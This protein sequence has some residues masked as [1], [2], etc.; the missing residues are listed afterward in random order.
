MANP[1]LITEGPVRRA[2]AL[3]LLL[4]SRRP[5]GHPV[6]AHIMS[7]SESARRRAPRAS[8]EPP[9]DH[10][11]PA[12]ESRPAPE[13][14]PDLE[15]F[16]CWADRLKA[17]A[18][19][20]GPRAAP[21]T[22]DNHGASSGPAGAD[23]AQ[24]SGPVIVTD[25]ER[26]VLLKRLDRYPAGPLM[27][28]WAAQWNGDGT[29]APE[30]RELRL[31]GRLLV[32]RAILLG[33]DG[34]TPAEISRV[35]CG[36][37]L[38]RPIRPDLSKP[39]VHADYI[40]RILMSWNSSRGFGLGV[41][42][43]LRYAAYGDVFPS[44][45]ELHR[46]FEEEVERRWDELGRVD[47]V[48]PGP[49]TPSPSGTAAPADPTEGDRAEPP[50]AGPVAPKPKRPRKAGRPKKPPRPTTLKELAAAIRRDHP[51]RKRVPRFLDLI[52]DN[53]DV[54]FE[55]IK[56]KVHQ[57]VVEEVTVEKTITDARKAIVDARL[58]IALVVSDRRVSQK[59]TS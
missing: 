59:T 25:A 38:T 22:C 58:P 50:A 44:L 39:L 35:F 45:E 24:F 46:R 57:A 52:A 56:E 53:D 11:T 55:E 54:S 12:H 20:A 49:A 31:L 47:H 5:G 51:R 43:R 27:A 10:S 16:R 15:G 41:A 8:S 9:P 36:E 3:L 48:P 37:G 34:R 13:A 32:A 19:R 18:D 23:H 7:E 1:G 14:H 33:G 4:T 6:G 28:H 30:M 29:P 21:S 17:E 40:G 2:R 42:R 26:V